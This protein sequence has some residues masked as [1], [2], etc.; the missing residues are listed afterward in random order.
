MTIKAQDFDTVIHKLGFET[1]DSRDR[2][3]WFIYKDKIIVRTKRSYKKGR[4]LPFQHVIRQQLKLTEE[5]LKGVIRCTFTREDYIE[6][7]KSKG[8]IVNDEG[9][10]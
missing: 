9:E 6:L 2:L 1:R 3:A 10:Q 5:Q 4:D 7:L 8:L